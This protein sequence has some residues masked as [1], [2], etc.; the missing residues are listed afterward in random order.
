MRHFLHS[1]LALVT[2]ILAGCNNAE[3]TF[4]SLPAYFVVE[5]TLQE[6]TVLHTALNNMGQFCTIRSNGNQ[7]VFADTRNTG[8]LPISQLESNRGFYLGL[9]GFIVGLPSIPEMGH[10]QSR[11]ICFDWACS[12]CYDDYSVA[13]RMTL[14]E[15]G[16]VSCSGCGRTYNLNDAGIVSDGEP[17]R[18]LFRYRISYVGNSM[19]ISNR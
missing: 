12:N 2:I 8:F 9:S 3:H 4:C 10:D 6:P 14:R 15:E 17:G 19:V 11:V 13:R 18:S 7:Y 5:N 16:Y 1:T